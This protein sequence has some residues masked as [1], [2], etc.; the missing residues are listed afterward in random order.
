MPQVSLPN[1]EGAVQVQDVQQTLSAVLMYL[2]EA[3]I[4]QGLSEEEAKAAVAREI[5]ALA[6]FWSSATGL[7]FNVSPVANPHRLLA[8][9]IEIAKTEA[10]TSPTPA[11][12]AKW[13]TVYRKLVDL[14]AMVKKEVAK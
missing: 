5:E 10:T 1:N 3:N 9:V 8:E 14:N 11:S 12:R 2:Y 13:Q 6:A 7:E 4:R